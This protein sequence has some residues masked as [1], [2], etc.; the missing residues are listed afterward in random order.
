VSTR[1]EAVV[2]THGPDPDLASCLSALGEQVGRIVIV[3]NLPGTPAQAPEGGLLLENDRPLGFAAN[4]NR[5]VRATS[6]P[7]VVVS[8]PDA[9]ASPGAVDALVAFAEHHPHAGILG[10]EMHYPDG[11]WQPSRRRFPTVGATIVRRTPLRLVFPPERYQRGH[12]Q[13]DDRPTEPTP[14]DWLLGG[15]LLVRRETFDALGGFDEG[16]RLYGEDIDFAYRA[17]QAG[18]ERWLVPA[19]TVVHQYHAV[20]DQRFLTRRTW[21]HLR[22]MVRFVRRH[23]ECL[24]SL[25]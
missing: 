2:V 19:A 12:Y 20:I 17:H 21:W 14:A 16:F 18:W 24:R 10:P 22:G 23:P 3:A 8:N 6:A 11:R 5:G 7:F 1:V 4:V 9:V 25:R 13:L 15:F